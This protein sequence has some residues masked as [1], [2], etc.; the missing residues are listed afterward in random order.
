MPS[1]IFQLIVLFSNIVKLDTFREEIDAEF[2][3]YVK[4]IT[5][6]EKLFS[7]QKSENSLSLSCSHVAHLLENSDHEVF[8]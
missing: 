5:L 6:R 1:R 8:V 4:K 2:G 3:E 7:L